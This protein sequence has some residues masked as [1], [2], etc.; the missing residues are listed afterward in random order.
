[1]EKK[2][3]TMSKNEGDDLYHVYE[4]TIDSKDIGTIEKKSCCGDSTFSF[5]SRSFSTG[6]DKWETKAKVGTVW[7]GVC[8]GCVGA[9]F[10]YKGL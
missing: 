6:S 4:T 1:M 2:L 8:N 5:D 7:K 9:L 3:F 10:D